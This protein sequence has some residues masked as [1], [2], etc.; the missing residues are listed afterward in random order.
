MIVK[1]P[2]YG[3]GMR[4]HDIQDHN[5]ARIGLILQVSYVSAGHSVDQAAA[6]SR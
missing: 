3:P 1:L 2:E 5:Y 4:T 6:K